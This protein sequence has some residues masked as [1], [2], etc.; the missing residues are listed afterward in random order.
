M[1]D[2]EISPKADGHR[3]MKKWCYECKYYR[4]KSNEVFLGWCDFNED[5]AIRVRW[6]DSCTE[7]KPK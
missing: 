5:A 6:S 1:R 4:E 2:Y 7:F 3:D